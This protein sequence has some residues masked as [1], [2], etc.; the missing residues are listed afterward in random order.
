MERLKFAR[1]LRVGQTDAEQRLWRHLRNRQLSGLK[2]RRQQPLGPYFADFYCHDCKLVIE[3]DGG[4][5]LESAVDAIRDAWL[6]A[7]GYRVLRFWNHDVLQQT[8]AV[9]EAI[10]QATR[11]APSPPAPLPGGE[12]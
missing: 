3:V 6:K 2:F 8:D 9:F 4:Q 11:S 7:S 1:Q 5:H 10:Y 12:G